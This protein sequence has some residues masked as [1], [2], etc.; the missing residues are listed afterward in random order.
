[1]ANSAAVNSDQ[2][3]DETEVTEPLQD[4]QDQPLD[5]SKRYKYRYC[6]YC[7]IQVILEHVLYCSH[8]TFTANMIPF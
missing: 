5:K 6:D 8:V 1:V 2:S 3:E 4:T 7:E